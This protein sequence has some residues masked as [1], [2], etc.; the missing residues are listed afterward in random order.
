MPGIESF[1]VATALALAC[2]YL[3]M[4]SSSREGMRKKDGERDRRR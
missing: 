3:L 2:I 1:C 4:V